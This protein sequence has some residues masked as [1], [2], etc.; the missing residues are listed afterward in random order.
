[1]ARGLAGGA[2]ARGLS[3]ETDLARLLAAM[4][5]VLGPDRYS[6][7]T[8]A[9]DAALVPEAFAIIREDEGSTVVFA[10]SDGAWARITLS[11]HSS[12]SAVGLTAAFSAALAAD[13][14]SANVIAGNLHDHI[15]VPWARRDDAMAALLSLSRARAG[16]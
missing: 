3:G 2:G 9:D 12:L 7:I 6:W 11:V 15:F 1:M 8:V 5:P 10:T 16:G 14:I 13:G 4:A